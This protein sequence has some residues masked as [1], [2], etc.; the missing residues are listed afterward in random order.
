MGHTQ[1][2]STVHDD[3]ADGVNVVL[4]VLARADDEVFADLVEP[5]RGNRLERTSH[6]RIVFKHRVEL[7]DGQREQAAVRLGAH[8]GYSPRVR[9]QTD[10]CTSTRTHAR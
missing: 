10:L 7:V 3:L 1:P 8:A 9:Q 2:I 5:L 4:E 6:D